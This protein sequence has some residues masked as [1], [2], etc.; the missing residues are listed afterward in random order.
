MTAPSRE[1]TGRRG[2]RWLAALGA[3]A[4]VAV[5]A[6][7]VG[8][9]TAPPSGWGAAALLLVGLPLAAGAGAAAALR[10]AGR[11]GALDAGRATALGTPFLA[12][13]GL[14]LAAAV[15]GPDHPAVQQVVAAVV[16]AAAAGALARHFTGDGSWRQP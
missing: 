13:L 14:L 5:V 9:V 16:G 12:G 15:A 2:D 3:G 10:L 8:V 6:A 7:L 1:A 4:A 11:R